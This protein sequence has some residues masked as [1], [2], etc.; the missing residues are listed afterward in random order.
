MWFGKRDDLAV[1]GAGFGI[2]RA[3]AYR[4]HDEAVQVLS[5]QD[6]IRTRLSNRPNR[7]VW[8][9]VI[10]DA[11]VFSSDRCLE[12]ATSVK[13]GQIDLW[14]SGKAHEHGG[15]VQSPL[16][17]ECHDCGSAMVAAQVACRA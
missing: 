13:D 16:R 4:C 5:E 12:K 10:L 17:A 2:S 6:R 3:T 14:Y 1:L 9:S 8:L 15:N 11:R 7:T